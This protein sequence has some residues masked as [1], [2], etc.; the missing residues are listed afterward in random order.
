MAGGQHA[1]PVYLTIGNISKDIR[2]K[3]SKRAT[4]I[5]GY[6]PV[7]NFKDVTEK[8]LRT[9]LR[10]ELLHR[11]MQAIVEPLKAAARDGVPMWCADNRLRRVYPIL[12]AFVGDWPEQNDMSCMVRSGCP[13]CRQGLRG[14]GSGRTDVQRRNQDDTVAAFKAYEKSNKKA[15]LRE[16]NLKPWT[17][18][19]ADLPHVDFPSCITP[20]ILHQFHKGVFKNYVAE[21]TEEI[22]GEDVL[23]TRFSAMPQAKGL[24]RFK[25]GITSV[26]QWTGRETK[27]MVKQF[28]PIIA[29]D[30]AVPD[31]F[32][33]M[34]R[35]LL[36]FLY[37][38]ESAQLSED[39]V[40]EMDEALRTFHS[41]KKILVEL[42]LITDLDKFDDIPKFHMLGHYTH[43]IREL[44]T[45]DGYNTE[46]PE[47]LHIIYAK[48][49][50]RASN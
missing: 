49:G 35:A 24:R 42:E 4:V 26:Q 19:W 41:L 18:F 32:V 2:R 40:K 36:D 9:K 44:G 10:G 3:A 17:P 1:Y 43:S 33:K 34:V 23:N 48:R 11:S 28:L 50:W 38:A 22:L 29:E 47:H 5:L 31:D 14:R 30:P 46:S 37:F 25:T 21:W 8:S 27:E 7:D 20:D 16:L 13:I 6:L 12:A 15:E 39:Q 45:P